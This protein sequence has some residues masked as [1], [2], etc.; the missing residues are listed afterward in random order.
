VRLRVVG[1]VAG[2]PKE[3]HGPQNITWWGALGGEV[4]EGFVLLLGLFAYLYLRHAAPSWPPLHDPLPSLGAPLLNLGLMLASLLPAWWASRAA[5]RHDRLQTT[6]ALVGH[7]LLGT[8]ILVVRYFECRALNVRWDTDAYG[9]IT[10]ALLF[11]HGYMALFD[12]F[13]TAGLLLLFLRLEPEEKHYIDVTENSF[14]WY[15]VLGTWL[16]LFALIFLSPRW[17]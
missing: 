13:D 3:V 6:L 15:F 11:S 10:W 2:Y 14:F 1:T 7:A 16:P 8:A 5:R 17:L 12:V 9:S 4:I